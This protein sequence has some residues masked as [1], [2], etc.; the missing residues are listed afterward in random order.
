[1]DGAGAAGGCKYRP[2]PKIAVEPF[3]RLWEHK[4]F[5]LLRERELKGEDV[6]AQMRTWRHS[7]FSVHRDVH[8]A[9]GD[10]RGIEDLA[11]YISQAPF[12]L[13]RILKVTPEGS[14]PYKSEHAGVKKFPHWRVAT[15]LPGIARNFEVFTALDFPAQS[16]LHIPNRGQHLIRYYGWYSNRAR[17]ERKK[18]GVTET[19]H[20]AS[21]AEDDPD[22]D[23][24]YRNAARRNWA[25]LIKKVY[26][27]DP[28]LCPKCGT[29][30][31]IVA[32]IMEPAANAN[33]L[34][35]LGIV[36]EEESRAPPRSL[37]GEPPGIEN[38]RPRIE[39]RRIARPVPKAEPDPV[40]MEDQPFPACEEY[41]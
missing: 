3:L 19:A 11:Q 16:T 8:L 2:L 38:A 10:K 4:I 35:S 32:F 12:S 31:A 23:A 17:G 15:T 26:E 37:S 40:E 14:V 6:V 28:L 13:A 25:R 21:A 29:E 33:I 7:G 30:M 34:A 39:R 22:R 36:E 27:V 9:A 18:S 5:R 24:E 41:G 20:V 1:M